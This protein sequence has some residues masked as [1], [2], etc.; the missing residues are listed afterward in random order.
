MIILPVKTRLLSAGDDL[1]NAIAE[2]VELTSGDIVVVSSKVAATLEGSAIKLSE[3]RPSDEAQK[4]FAEFGKSPEHREF[5]LRET[6]RMNGK[7]IRTTNGVVL[8]ELK[9]EGLD[10]SLLVPNAG[11]DE[12]NIDRGWAVGWP[13]DPVATVRKLRKE[14][15]RA[16]NCGGAHADLS[17]DIPQNGYRQSV[18]ILVEGGYCV[19][20]HKFFL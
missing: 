3:I 1:C 15:S 8:T 13:K 10:G 6:R 7:V 2:S 11:I 4:L 17:Q 12:S 9:P 18:G 14:L 19:L 5:V 16:K 20:V